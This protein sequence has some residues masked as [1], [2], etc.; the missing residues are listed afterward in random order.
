MERDIHS[1]LSTWFKRE[2][3]KPLILRGARQI[4][5]SHS[6]R[7]FGKKH[8]LTLL[9]INFEKTPHLKEL[10]ESKDMIKVKNLLELHF[11]VSLGAKPVKSDQAVTSGLNASPPLR[12]LLFLDEI[13]VAPELIACLRYFYEDWPEL[14]VIVAGSLLDFALQEYDYSMPVGRI[15]YCYMGPMTFE[16]FLQ[17]QGNIPL[18]EF[19]ANYKLPTEIPPLIH[20]L[21]LEQLRLFTFLG[22]MPEVIQTYLNTQDFSQC[23]QVQA[24]L[25]Q[26][27]QEDFH[28]YRKRVPFERLSHLFRTIPREVGHKLMYSRI[29]PNERS[30]AVGKAL[31][32]LEYAQVIYKVRHT[33]GNGIPLAAETDPKAFKVLFVDLGLLSSLLG[34]NLNTIQSDADL[35]RVHEGAIAEQFIGQ[36]LMFSQLPYISPELFY[37]TREIPGS[38]SEVDYLLAHGSQVIP[39]EVKAGKSGK[40]KS[41]RLFMKEKKKKIGVRFSIDP[42]SQESEL[43]HLP[44]YLVGQLH[45]LLDEEIEKRHGRG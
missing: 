29:A 27:Y 28:K 17:A 19:L 22:G 45:R 24:S 41:L 5:K 33:A 15:E 6:V 43:I 40:L 25:I 26:T 11:S 23:N 35:I 16:E 18:L 3:R 34:L 1:Y 13:Q 36:H 31:Q 37:W 32:L 14:P 38:M 9:E 10:F 20:R 8:Q 30:D 42:P 12:Y 4:G 21:L 39:I 44:L 2:P 7:I